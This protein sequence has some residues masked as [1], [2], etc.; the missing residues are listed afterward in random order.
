MANIYLRMPT[1]VAQFY[2]ALDG[3]HLLSETEPYEFCEFQHEYILMKN[4]L[5]LIPEDQQTCSW[6][7]SQRAWNNILAGKAPTGGPVIISRSKGQ[8][9][10]TGELCGLVGW[11]SVKKLDAYD[12]LCIAMP[13]EV[14]FG[15]EVR[16]TN[17]SYSL[18]Q[19]EA[20]KLQR[21]LRDEFK[22]TILDWIIQDRRYCNKVGIRREIG[23]TIERFFERYY[24]TIGSNK[25]ERETMYKLV[26]R[27]LDEAHLL[28]ND[29][30][31][32]SDS[33]IHYVSE[34]ESNH[35]EKNDFNTDIGCEIMG[36]YNS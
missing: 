1:Y 21:L 10:T 25:K 24:I 15:G 35:R 19:T 11:K 36:G 33:D 16:R 17:A 18:R 28:T 7:F 23:S 26:R 4:Q 30:V 27:W 14:I 9:P 20:M 32:F 3:N 2:R 13:K 8:W 34:R 22:H 5:L 6:C 12:Y 31:D 29:R